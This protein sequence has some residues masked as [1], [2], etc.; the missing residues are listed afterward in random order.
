MNVKLI[1]GMLLIAGTALGAGMLAIPMVLAQFGLLWGTLLMLAIWAGTTYA[2][3]LLLEATL[4]SGGG[5]GMNSIAQ[6]T[7]GKQGQL[8]TNALLY[9]LVTCLMIAYIV[10]AGDLVQQ[11]LAQ[12]GVELGLWE[13]QLLFTGVIGAFIAQGTASVDKLN[14][15]LFIAM[16]G[17]LFITLIFLLPNIALDNFQQQSN[18]NKIE[19]IK[20]SAVLFTSFGFMV[21][22]PSVVKY[23]QEATYQQLRNMV[24]LGSMLPLACYLLWLIAVVGNLPATQLV[25]FQNVSELITM[26]SAEYQNLAVVLSVFTGLAIVTSF[27]GVAMSLFD[28]NKDLFKTN[29]LTTFLTTFSLP[30]FGAIW[31]K[32]Q[33]IGVLGYAGIILVFL[34]VFIP[35]AMVLRVRSTHFKQVEG[36]FYQVAGG[37]SALLGCFAFG[38]FLLFSQLI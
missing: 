6:K 12:V 16:I 33:F 8:I 5:V 26:L 13:S 4:R 3:L 28:Q 29:K 37:K 25:N 22:V 14:R 35:M 2:A 1:G 27:L 20:N 34:A 30:L 38:G 10:S 23:N 24:I 31:A 9:C 21:V 11:L 15:V 17:M 32:E 19:L 18:D 36:P 7:L